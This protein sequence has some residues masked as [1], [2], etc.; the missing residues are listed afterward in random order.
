M[1]G[2]G[3]SESL[4]DRVLRYL[5]R[6]VRLLL[7]VAIYALVLWYGVE[8]AQKLD[9]PPVVAGIAVAL[10]ALGI[11]GSIYR[12]LIDVA[13]EAKGSIMALAAFL[14]DKLVKP[15]RRRLRAE[16]REEGL[17]EGRAEGRAETIT[18][19]RARL[20]EQGI[21]PDLIFPLDG[22][23]DNTDEADH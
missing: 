12:I 2:I 21:D 4:W 3:E 15:Q 11:A 19:G 10:I 14:N 22:E 1:A 5:W 6:L 23:A 17:E 7:A 18:E 20:I 16:G 13:K 8:T 9:A